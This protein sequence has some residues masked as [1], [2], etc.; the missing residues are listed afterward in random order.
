MTSQFLPDP[1]ADLRPEFEIRGRVAIV[2]FLRELQARRRLVTVYAG[3]GTDAFLVTS[4]IDVGTDGMLVD[5][6][7]ASGPRDAL[8]RAGRGTLVGFLE[9]VKLQTDLTVRG[10]IDSPGQCLL[11]VALPEVLWRIQR[12]EAFRVQPLARDLAQVVIRTRDGGERSLRVADLSVAGVGLTLPVGM[13]RP[14]PGERWMHSRLEV[15][16]RAPIPCDLKVRN[17]REGS[18]GPADA[19][20]LGCLFEHLP[21]EV[22]RALQIYVIDTERAM[23]P[24]TRSV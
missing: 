11:D 2:R 6:T 3:D 21:S 1:P 10:V 18:R 14:A 4:L 22:Q 8:L 23:R 24:G 20:R 7:T 12:R 16:G 13:T 17:V 19:V 5:F 9:D 15:N